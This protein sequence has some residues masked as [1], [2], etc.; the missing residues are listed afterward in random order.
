MRFY[1][2]KNFF[3]KE[4]TC[5][6][7]GKVCSRLDVQMFGV[8]KAAGYEKMLHEGPQFSGLALTKMIL[9][10][11]SL[12]GGGWESGGHL[13]GWHAAVRRTRSRAESLTAWTSEVPSFLPVTTGR[14]ERER[15]RES[16]SGMFTAQ[17][18]PLP[19]ELCKAL[20]LKS[21]SR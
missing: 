5:D 15:P 20:I 6:A 2:K 12:S 11:R 19:A 7:T 16:E 14:L 9:P 21:K 4:K 17:Q 18:R 3:T 8:E 10:L 13:R 1:I